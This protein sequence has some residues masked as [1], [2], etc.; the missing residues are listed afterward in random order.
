MKVQRRG[1]NTAVILYPKLATMPS[2]IKSDNTAR[3]TKN[4]AFNVVGKCVEAK[5]LHFSNEARNSPKEPRRRR[6][7]VNVVETHSKHLPP[8]LPANSVSQATCGHFFSRLLDFVTCVSLTVAKL[9]RIQIAFALVGWTWCLLVR[10]RFGWKGRILCCRGERGV[11]KQKGLDLNSFRYRFSFCNLK[12][13][14]A[15]KYPGRFT[16]WGTGVDGDRKVTC[17]IIP[18]LGQTSLFR[19]SHQLYLQKNLI[20]SCWF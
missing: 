15:G 5:T 8:P 6:V 2:A 1:A 11:V 17:D 13:G 7:C 3:D 14:T 9:P 18:R 12:S 4:L 16:L 10:L 20:P 19:I